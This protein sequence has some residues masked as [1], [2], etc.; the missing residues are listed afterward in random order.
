[1]TNFSSVNEIL[2]FAINSEQEAADFYT[3]LAKH[4]EKPWMAELFMDFSQQEMG[5]KAKLEAVK[6]GEKLLPVEEK[7]QDLKIAD[8]VVDVTE[9]EDMTYQEALV[10]A[11]KRE[12]ASFKLYI[13]LANSTDDDDLKKMFQALAQE[14][15]RHKLHIETEYD[16]VILSEN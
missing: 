9:Q 8:Y 5:H 7:V 11:M 16:D 6:I 15:A 3:R 2:D 14:E 1:M 12:K 10:V 4:M 13:T